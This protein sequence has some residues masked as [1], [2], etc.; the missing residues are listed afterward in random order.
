MRPDA[1]MATA[2]YPARREDPDFTLYLGDVREVLR[3]LPDASV[4][5]VVTSPPFFGLRDYGVEGQI[6]LE[7]TP[8]EWAA[9]LTAVFA[10]ARR[11]L[12][13]HGTLWIECGDLYAANRSY[14]VSQSKHKSHDYGK[15]NA[16]KAPPGTKPKDLIG[17]PFLLAFALRADGWYWRSTNIWQKPNCLPESADDRPTVSHSYVFQFSQRNTPIYWTHR[18]GR[19]VSRKPTPDHRWVHRKTGDEVAVAPEGWLEGD[20][21]VRETWSRINLWKGRDYFHDA[22]AVREPAE[23]ERWGDQPASKVDG[24]GA[25]KMPA[26]SKGEIE[27]IAARGPGNWSVAPVGLPGEG[28][29]RGTPATEVAARGSRNLRSVWTIPTE[30]FPEAHFATW[31]SKLVERILLMACPAQV[32]RECGKARERVVDVDYENPGNR[33]T[34]GPRSLEQRHETAGFEVRR[35]KRT[36]TLGFTDCPCGPDRK[37][38]DR[39]A[40]YRPGIVLDPFMG[41]GTTA[42]VARKLGRHAVGIELN[43]EYAAMCAR[44]LSQ[45]SLLAEAIG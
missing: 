44:R 18:D 11:I 45:L 40:K 43:E 12:A 20:E 21:A 27:R 37:C 4:D 38:A 24:I 39:T 3:E 13:A 7:P 33:Q 17:A 26:R 25:A 22:E 16:T 19:L 23:W 28:E 8:E 41:S 1:E 30:G 15:S 42:L 35:E 32:C 14:Q 6:G 2:S 9:T 36:T 34:N 5:C 29:S 10:E 31:P